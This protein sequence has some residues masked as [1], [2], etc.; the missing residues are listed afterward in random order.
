MQRI[1][2]DMNWFT[3]LPVGWWALRNPHSLW[4]GFVVAYC[5]EPRHVQLIGNSTKGMRVNR[6]SPRAFG[7][8]IDIHRESSLTLSSSPRQV[9]LMPSNNVPISTGQSQSMKGIIT[10]P[11]RSLHQQPHISISIRWSG[12]SH[13]IQIAQ[14]GWIDAMIYID[15]FSTLRVR[16]MW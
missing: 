15:T 9:P 16:S 14:T 7:H 4:S 2:L 3:L 13:G 12:N 11:G 1:T 8:A 10:S 6:Y 5:P